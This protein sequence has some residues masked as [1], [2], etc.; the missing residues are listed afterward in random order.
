MINIL[1]AQLGEIKNAKSELFVDDLVIRH[2]C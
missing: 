1:P 2:R